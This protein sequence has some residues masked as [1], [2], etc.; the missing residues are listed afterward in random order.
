[1][2]TLRKTAR[3]ERAK[4]NRAKV[5][6]LKI[7]ING[8]WF[9]LDE[10]RQKLLPITVI[11]NILSHLISGIVF[12]NLFIQIEMMMFILFMVPLTTN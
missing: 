8:K 1:M 6:H 5:W 9:C 11:E 12:T 2:W 7:D 4:G 10:V 3:D